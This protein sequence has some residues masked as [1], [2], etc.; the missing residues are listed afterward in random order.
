MLYVPCLFADAAL[1][2]K[3]LRQMEIE[4]FLVSGAPAEVLRGYVE[5]LG[6][7]GIYGFELEEREGRLTGGVACNY[8]VDKDRALLLPP[9]QASA[10]I[11]LHSMGDAVADIPLL[12]N[13]RVPVIVGENRLKLREGLK[14]LRFASQPW[15]LDQLEHRLVAEL[16][17]VNNCSYNI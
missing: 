2:F 15:D 13:A 5:K 3:R 6:I 11:H 4:V 16:T 10:C 12:E 1:L 9:F 14:P 17:S 7:K 8:G